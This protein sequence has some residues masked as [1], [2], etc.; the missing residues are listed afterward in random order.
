MQEN[1]AWQRT[2]KR[3]Q[4]FDVPDTTPVLIMRRFY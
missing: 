4:S 2:A 1:D 3:H